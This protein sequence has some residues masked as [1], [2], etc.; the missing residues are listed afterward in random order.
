[1][2]GEQIAKAQ[3]MN[4]DRLNPP[5]VP[6]VAAETEPCAAY[7]GL[8]QDDEKAPGRYV[9]KMTSAQA[10]WYA[11]NGRKLFPG[12]CLSLEKARY[13]LV[14][15]ISTQS[16]TI[17]QTAHRTAS[18]DTSTHG[19][20]DGTFSTYGSLSMRGTYSGTFSSS[21]WSTVSYQETV[22]VTITADHCSIYVL[23]SV[24]PTI[25]D[26]IRN[27]T[28]QPFAIFSTETRGGTKISDFGGADGSGAAGLILASAISRAVRREPTTHALVAALAFISTQP[29]GEVPARQTSAVP[30]GTDTSEISIKS[31]P[32]GA[33]I[34]VDG[35]YMGGAPSVIRLAAGDHEIEVA[36]P[37]FNGW[38]RKMTVSAG[39]QVTIDAT[40]DTETPR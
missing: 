19:H 29:V 37:G 14:W 39:G 4:Q 23:K 28:P 20:E 27:K 5:A 30:D 8:L 40:L 16:R 33:D 32:E 11:K 31:T 6:Q 25:W 7:V 22:P 15:S 9:A 1:M 10:T 17:H 26:D 18:V 12:L 3:Q 2:T 24:G 21:S 36:K 34:I 35:K 38:T 13:L